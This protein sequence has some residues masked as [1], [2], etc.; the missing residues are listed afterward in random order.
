MKNAGFCIFFDWIETLDFLDEADAYKV[1]KALSRYYTDGINPVDAVPNN[2]KATVN[3]MYQQIKR[4]EKVSEER[5]KAGR[6]SAEARFVDVCSNNVEQKSTPVEQKSTTN[7]NT[8]TNT[9]T[10]TNTDTLLSPS[11]E[12]E[13]AREK[14]RFVPPTKDEVFAYMQERGETDYTVAESFVDY[15][16]NAK[17]RVGS[18]RTVM[19]DW[20][21][22]VRN[23]LRRERKGKP[24]VKEKQTESSF[25]TDDFM[26]ASLKRVYGEAGA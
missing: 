14:K 1:I 8:N 15:Y 3:L 7:T 24:K 17:W 9:E 19:T 25:D 20:K 23:W 11:N 16:V 10:N 4:A 12:G 18:S 2:I 26:L 6:A 21:A 5:A 13:R 22:A